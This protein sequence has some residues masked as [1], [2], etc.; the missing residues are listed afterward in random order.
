MSQCETFGFFRD[1]SGAALGEGGISVNSVRRRACL[2]S[3]LSAAILACLLPPSAEPSW[4]CG[5]GARVT[6]LRI[7]FIKGF[8]F[9]VRVY[10]KECS[11]EI[12]KMEKG[13]Y[14]YTQWDSVV[15]ANVRLK[16]AP[17]GV[18]DS[19]SL[20]RCSA[21]KLLL[22]H[23]SLK[24]LDWPLWLGPWPFHYYPSIYIECFLIGRQKSWLSQIILTVRDTRGEFQ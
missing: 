16:K 9:R 1:G 2:F 4:L 8:L 18:W 21:L 17:V 19:S 24:E 14:F 22:L 12:W 7:F 23:F 5:R 10:S 15:Q 11:G 3:M 20:T 13:S 6:F